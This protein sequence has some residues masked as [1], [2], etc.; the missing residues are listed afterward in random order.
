MIK[1]QSPMEIH[2]YLVSRAAL[3]PDEHKRF[4]SPH[5]YKTGISA[6]LT[7]TRNALSRQIKNQL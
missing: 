1:I 5:I 7:E 2:K 6:E 4:I 3:L